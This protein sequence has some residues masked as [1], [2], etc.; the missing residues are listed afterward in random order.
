MVCERDEWG[1]DTLFLIILSQLCAS[2]VEARTHRGPTWP[3]RMVS[4]CPR[5]PSD[6]A[7]RPTT[8][9]MCYFAVVGVCCVCLETAEDRA[10]ALPPVVNN[11]SGSRGGAETPTGMVRAPKSVACAVGKNSCAC[12]SRLFPGRQSDHI[13]S[14]SGG[15]VIKRGLRQLGRQPSH[16]RSALT[17]THTYAHHAWWRVGGAAAGDAESGRRWDADPGSRAFGPKRFRRGR[18]ARAGA[19]HEDPEVGP[20]R[21]RL[22]PVGAPGIGL[23]PTSHRGSCR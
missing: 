1:S 9:S 2:G 8:L 18:R 5:A 17:H 15:R 19:A 23:G 21:G 4:M 10:C 20:P 12:V 3:W 11:N 6:G 16:T 22:L 7:H 14:R 13:S